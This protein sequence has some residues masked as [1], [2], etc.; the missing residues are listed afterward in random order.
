MVGLLGF[1]LSLSYFFCLVVID[2]RRPWTSTTWGGMGMW[3]KVGAKHSAGAVS[4][5][6]SVRAWYH[7]DRTNPCMLKRFSYAVKQSSMKTKNQ[8][9]SKAVELFLLGPP[10]KLSL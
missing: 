1:F 7:S 8:M 4:H 9:N 2:Y 6:V 3:G 10:N 5:P